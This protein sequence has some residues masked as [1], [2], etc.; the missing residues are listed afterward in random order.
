[1]PRYNIKYEL[2]RLNIKGFICTAQMFIASALLDSLTDEEIEELAPTYTDSLLDLIHL[3][4]N[5]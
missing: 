2:Y 3:N 4:P 1:M 5:K